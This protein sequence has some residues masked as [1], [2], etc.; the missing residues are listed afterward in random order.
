MKSHLRPYAGPLTAEQVTQGIAAAQTNANRILD[1]AKF[2][3]EAGRFPTAAAL[4]ILS[5]EERGKVSILKRI[6][7]LTDEADLKSAWRDYR[8]HRAKN[9]GWI[10]PELVMQGARTMRDMAAAVDP[11][12]DHTSILDALKQVSIYTDCLAD[13]HWSCPSQV[14]DEALAR[15]MISTAE[16]MWNAKTV[17][18]REIELWMEIVGPNYN[19]PTMMEAVIRW[20]R[21]LFDEGFSEIAPESL[22]SFMRGAP[23]PLGEPS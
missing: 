21:A 23:T 8:S 4:A 12:G 2:L 9:A 13:R 20:Q 22:E 18:L 1:D 3:C 10:L 7:L 17:S 14:V 5:L 16:L 6:A 11:K 19:R 15:S